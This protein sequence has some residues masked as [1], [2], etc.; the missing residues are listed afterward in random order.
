MDNELC[1][2]L[3]VPTAFL[4]GITIGISTEIDKEKLSVLAIDAISEVSDPRLGLPNQTSQC[5]TCGAKDLKSCEGHFGF[6]KFPFTL[7]HPYFLSEVAKILNKIC[8]GCKSIRKDLLVKCQGADSVYRKQQPRGCKYC[9][10]KSE[11]WYP[12]MKFKVSTKELS[13]KTAIIVEMVEKP[14]KKFHKR[15]ADDYWNFVIIRDAQQEESC[16]KEKRM[17]LS[18]SQVHYL[19]KDVDQG[20]IEK[21]VSKKD[22]IF[23][24]CFPVTPNSH[25]VTEITHRF[26][27]GKRLMFDA[28]TRAY[29]KMVDFRGNAHELSSLVYDCLKISKL[30]LDKSS[31]NDYGDMQQ[32]KG[33]DISS[34]SGLR[35]LKDVVLGKR[36]DHC[37][38]MVV[39]GDP[40]IKLSEIGIPCHI[41][42]RLQISEH[43]NSWNWE[44]LNA[45]SSLRLLEKGKIHVRRNG[46]LV[47]VHRIDALQV[48]DVIFRPLSD[49]DIILI[50]RPPSI[51]QHSLIALSVKVLPVSSVVTINPLCCS[52]FRGDFDGDCLHGYV[53]QSVDA[54]VE[55]TELV[56][57]DRQLVNQQSGRN[58]LSLSHDS[59]TAAHLVMEDGVYLSLVE[60]QQLQMFCP[61]RTLSPP[62]MEAPSFGSG[63]WTGKQL[64]SMLL[65]PDFEYSFPSK[66]VYISKGELIS[67]EGSSW[68]RDNDGNLFQSLIEHFQGKT[69]DFLYV[70]QEVLCEWLSMRGLSV[71]L[72]DLYL[73]A[74]SCTR[75]IMMDEIFYGLQEAEQTCNFKQLMVDSCQDFLIGVGDDENAMAFEVERLCYEKQGSAAL[76]QASVDAFKQVFWDIQ[77]LVY[78][79]AS[80]DNALVAMFKAGSKGNLLKLVQQSMCLGVQHS[81]APLSFRFPHK[82]SCEA[83]DCLKADDASG[84]AKSYIPY[85]VVENSFLT[86]LNPLECFVNS[87]TSRDSSFSDNADLPGTLNRRLSF[88]MRD[89]YTAYDGTVRNAYGNQLIQFSYDIKENMVTR[90][91]GT[92]GHPVGSM[93][94]CAISEAAYSALDQPISLLETSPLLNLKNVLECGSKKSYADQTMSLYLSKKLGTRR[95]GFEYGALEVKNHLECLNFSDI[96]STVMI[97]YSPQTSKKTHFSPWICHFHVC[98]EIVKR[99]RLRVHSI[100]DSLY[101]QCNLAKT[102]SKINLPNVHISSKDCS[103]INTQKE[104]SDT[105][106]I[107]FAIVENSERFSIQLETIQNSVIPFLLKTVIKGFPEIKK[108]DILWKD[109][110][111]ASKS[112]DSSCGELYLRVFMSRVC[113]RSSLWS[114][115]MNECLQIMDMIDW[116]RSHPDNIN[117]FC[118]ANGID[119][120][121]LCFLN[122]LESAISDTGKTILPEHLLILANS[123]SYTGEFVGLNAKGLAKQRG[124]ASISSP[125]MQ[126]CFSNP[127][128]CFIKA[129]KEGVVDNLQGSIDA[130]AWGKVPSVGTGGHFDLIYSG[131][132]QELAKP[133]DVYNLLSTTVPSKQ[134]FKV[135]L[136]NDQGRKS[137]ICGDQFANTFGGSS[138]KGLNKLQI[139]RELLRRVLTL[140]DIQ[141]LDRKLRNILYKY[142]I[143]HTLNESDTETL[144]LALY[145]HPRSAEKIGAGPQKIK[146]TN[147]PEYQSTRCF[148]VERADGTIEDFSYHKC[149]AGALEIIA[150]GRVDWYRSK[151]LRFG[152]GEGKGFKSRSSLQYGSR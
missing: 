6:I 86:G 152:S 89:L 137:E 63:I 99:R 98:K 138:T 53:P 7:Q 23:L 136:C 150:P 54:R 3:E 37:F 52:P 91:D 58:L 105:S 114:I 109:L 48:G 20:F 123:L 62:I 110:P 144:M 60:M 100:I 28:R 38:R 107:T 116:T 139:S 104:Y 130:L 13:R 90:R 65:P 18:P 119:A 80:K 34:S 11:F 73:S 77:N 40:N 126:A 70:A 64:F 59:L 51:H 41:A 8:P 93:S 79:Y 124:N 131:E 92:G 50:N 97:I 146:V 88:F 43:L 115:L 84:F 22:S 85:A 82:L 69:L 2:E 4:N 87:V 31:N 95:H 47:F 149:V 46:S 9:V 113:R 29:K 45:C 121:L 102:E 81:L 106:C 147:H 135:D 120:G 122:D 74:D 143:D 142:P 35:W 111:K 27:S 12:R 117:S 39:T 67:S 36:N 15:L 75:T 127:G 103:S 140:N 55:L 148:S 49:G 94:A 19:L 26:S 44:R 71:S 14:A 151:C 17:V 83:W 125:F 33:N 61:Y 1:E 128:V 132:G 25:R 21:F 66:G 129:A 108:V 141:N 72:S 76:S 56:A 101:K 118:L 30:H 5:S 24:N 145:F 68:L 42:E 57:L 134:H 78:K 10:G 112:H 32:N 96:V 133:V 16:K